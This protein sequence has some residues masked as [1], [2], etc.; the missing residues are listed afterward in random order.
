MTGGH[1]EGYLLF[2]ISHESK[3]VLLVWESQKTLHM[4]M[5]SRLEEQSQSMER[6]WKTE[7]VLSL[8]YLIVAIVIGA[9]STV[10]LLSCLLALLHKLGLRCV[11][12][13]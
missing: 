11:G 1:S 8:G 5:D 7:M 10:P 3:V 2:G 13:E 12:N 6:F 9:T 4:G